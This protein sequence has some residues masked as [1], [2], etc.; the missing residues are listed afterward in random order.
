MTQLDLDSPVKTIHTAAGR[1]K[2][3]A[4]VVACGGYIE[5]LHRKLAGALQ[6]VATYVMVT[7]PLG[8]RLRTAIRG[9]QSVIDSRFDFDYYRPLLDTRVSGAAASPSAAAIRPISGR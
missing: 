2:A 1:I 6:S 7:E 9:N 8:D 3:G 5:G 4:V